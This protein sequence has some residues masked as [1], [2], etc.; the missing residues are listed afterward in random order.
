MLR[1]GLASIPTMVNSD[2]DD[3]PDLVDADDTGGETRGLSDVALAR[4]LQFGEDPRPAIPPPPP[5]RPS[6]G[7]DDAAST[8]SASADAEPLPIGEVMG[9][10]TLMA[11]ILG[12][13]DSV[14][15]LRPTLPP[16]RMAAFGNAFD[17]TTTTSAPLSAPSMGPS[18]AQWR[19]RSARAAAVRSAGARMDIARVANAL[20]NATISEEDAVRA[21]NAGSAA[22]A[23]SLASAGVNLKQLQLWY[24]AIKAEVTSRLEQYDAMERKLAETESTNRVLG[25]WLRDFESSVSP[26]LSNADTD[27]SD[28]ARC[29]LVKSIQRV[30]DAEH[31]AANLKEVREK[32]DE[33]MGALSR[34]A[35][36]ASI[37]PEVVSQFQ[38]ALC[39]ERTCDRAYIPCGHMLCAT[40][41]GRST[42]DNCFICRTTIGRVLRLYAN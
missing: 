4:L 39:M 25:N 26:F 13:P 38:C 7:D 5:P 28:D 35:R 24:V 31:R 22:C 8:A 3:M 37:V 15:L 17:M 42:S 9:P 27:D 20:E 1:C 6:G 23:E 29:E 21:R 16:R 32:R 18:H 30:A 2:S 19:P 33:A 36:A 14:G 11:A 10:A 40:C 12:G 34:A 41:D